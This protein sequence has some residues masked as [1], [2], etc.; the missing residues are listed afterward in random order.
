MYP[1][2]LDSFVSNEEL[3]LR[4]QSG[5]RE[6]AELL[7][8]QNEGYLTKLA[9]LLENIEYSDSYAED[10]A[11]TY[12]RRMR[13]TLLLRLMDEVLNPRERNLVCYHLGIGQPDDNGVTFQ[14]LAIRLNYNGPS[15]AEKAY[16]TALRKL[17]EMY[18]SAYCRCLSIQRAIRDAEAETAASH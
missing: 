15:G 9:Q 8:V 2:V 13:W 3:A 16:K 4:I 12:D 14:E 11:V 6:A 18:S 1:S 7:I 17:K 10:P 5:D